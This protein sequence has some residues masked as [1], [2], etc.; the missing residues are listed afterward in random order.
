[1]G[2]TLT[3]HSGN[4]IE[5]SYNFKLLSNGNTIREDLV[6]DGVE[7]FT[8]YS[9]K[10]GVLVIKH[11]CALGTEPMFKVAKLSN[12]SI[13]LNLIHHPAI[14]KTII[15]LLILFHGNYLIKIPYQ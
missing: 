5:A 14:T 15:I 11:Y 7:M 10:D 1:M 6:E 3:Q 8:T 9:D 12:N 2:G 13:A 4:V